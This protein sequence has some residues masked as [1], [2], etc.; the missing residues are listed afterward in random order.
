MAGRELTQPAIQTV[1]RDTPR[2]EDTEVSTS[3]LRPS[4]STTKRCTKCGEVKPLDQYPRRHDSRD[5]H[6]AQCKSCN[7][8]RRQAWDD[9][10]RDYKKAARRARRDEYAERERRYNKMHRQAWR[11]FQRQVQM[12]LDHHITLSPYG[13]MPAEDGGVHPGDAFRVDRI[14]WAVAWIQETYTPADLPNPKITDSDLARRVEEAWATE[15]GAP[16]WF[17][18]GEAV[19]AAILA[20]LPVDASG[21]V[22]CTIGI[23]SAQYDAVARSLREGVVS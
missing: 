6:A 22:H 12:A 10:N 1:C 20:G 21:D 13:L 9:A 5:G 14:L 17:G 18:P 7:N 11:V 2:K 3:I 16:D 19:V 15:H 23:D 4:P 8:A